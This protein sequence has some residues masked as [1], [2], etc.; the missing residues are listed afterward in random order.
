M[1]D[2]NAA[3]GKA[4]DSELDH[5]QQGVWLLAPATGTSPNVGRYSLSIMSTNRG[6]NNLGLPIRNFKLVPGTELP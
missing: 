2:L 4:F 1:E 5:V 6:S 3:L